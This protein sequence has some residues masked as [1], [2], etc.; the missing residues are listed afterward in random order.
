RAPLHLLPLPYT[1]LFRSPGEVRLREH[2]A[3]EAAVFALDRLR[4]LLVVARRR[5]LEVERIDRGARAANRLNFVEQLLQRPHLAAE[6]QR[7][8]EHTSE[9]QSLTN[10]VC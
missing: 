9:L 4:H 5:A 8:A 6:Q 3:V 1:T 2:D 7:S 10:L